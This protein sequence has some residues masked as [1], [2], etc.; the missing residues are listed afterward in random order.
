LDKEQPE[1]N[2]IETQAKLI[3]LPSKKLKLKKE[4]N[5]VYT[6]LCIF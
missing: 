5:K 4:G 6:F 3:G 1:K 2:I